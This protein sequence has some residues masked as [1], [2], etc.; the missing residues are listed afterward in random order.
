M[1]LPTSQCGSASLQFLAMTRGE[2]KL[3]NRFACF[4]FVCGG[5]QFFFPSGW[6]SICNN[7][8]PKTS[9]PLGKLDPGCRHSK[10]G[11]ALFFFF[12][13]VLQA[14]LPAQLIYQ[15]LNSL[16]IDMHILS[17]HVDVLERDLTLFFF[18]FSGKSSCSVPF[19]IPRA[20]FDVYSLQAR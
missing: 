16:V 18:F 4:F 14:S 2:Q 12:L 15:T 6:I 5:V 9:I 1:S 20:D 19:T 17:A 3:R 13:N 8:L 7:H 10:S 11:S